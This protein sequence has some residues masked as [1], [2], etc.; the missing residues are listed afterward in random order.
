MELPE[1]WH[2]GMAPVRCCIPETPSPE[3]VGRI[4]LSDACRVHDTDSRKL[5]PEHDKGPRELIHYPAQM[6]RVR[7]SRLTGVEQKKNSAPQA[8][9]FGTRVPIDAGYEITAQF[10]EML[11]RRSLLQRFPEKVVT[12]YQ[13]SATIYV[14]RLHHVAP[15]LAPP[16]CLTQFDF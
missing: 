5:E 6:R 15:C 1:Y 12:S 11:W 16:F 3:F 4:V 13:T 8:D 7:E 14:D 2:N 10:S 9:N